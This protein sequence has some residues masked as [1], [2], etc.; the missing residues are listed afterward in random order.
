MEIYLATSNKHKVFEFSEMFATA[1]IDCNVHPA[2]DAFGFEPPEEDGETFEQNAFIKADALR[3][4]VPADAY[5]MADD[6]GI[7]VDALGGAPGIRSARYAGVSGDGADAANNK[8]LLANL[9]GVPDAERTARFVCVI[10]LVCPNGE[11]IAFHGKIEGQINHGECGANGFGYDPLF[12][13]PERG[14]TTAQLSPEDKNAISHRGR[15]FAKLAEFLKN[16]NK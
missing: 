7:V 11:R 2:S 15:A 16:Q 12:L 10:A 8:K 9:E 6:S 13:L 3:S 14:I 5:V 4:K 1:G